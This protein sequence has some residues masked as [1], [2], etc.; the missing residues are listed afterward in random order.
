MDTRNVVLAV[1]VGVVALTG[2]E[3]ES[4][5]GESANESDSTSDGGGND[6]SA[7]RC[8][9]AP[10]R[11]VRAIAEGFTDSAFNLENAQMV[12]VPKVEQNTEGYPQ[13]MVAANMTAKKGGDGPIGVWA[14]NL[15]RDPGPILALNPGAKTITDWGAAIHDGSP[16]AENRDIMASSDSAAAVEKC[17]S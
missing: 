8:K 5:G 13:N 2:C 7:S 1:V 15:P 6:R 16:M 11:A 17:L 4:S 9:K 3:S 14:I 12:A 10:P